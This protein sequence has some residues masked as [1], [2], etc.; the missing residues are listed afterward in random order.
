MTRSAI[1]CVRPLIAMKRLK[2]V[3]NMK[4]TMMPAVRRRVRSMD[5]QNAVEREA[6]HQ[7]RDNQRAENAQP[8]RFV[9]R[10]QSGIDAAQ[11]QQHQQQA[12]ARSWRS[13]RD[14]RASCCVRR[15]APERRI[16]RRAHG[17]QHDQDE[18]EQDARQDARDEQ[19]ADRDLGDHAVDDEGEARRHHHADGRRAGDRRRG[20]L[21]VV[22]VGLHLRQRDRAHAVDAGQGVS[23][24]RRKARA[25]DRAGRREPARQ[26]ADPPVGRAVELLGKARGD[27]DQPHPGEQRHD[28]PGLI[29]D[30]VDGRRAEAGQ[31]RRGA[32][33]QADAD[34]RGD[35]HRGGD[36]DAEED[37]D[38]AEADA[39]DAAQIA[40][41]A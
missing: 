1:C 28:A 39:Q 4:I 3:A 35:R 21:H 37:Q 11:D 12:P 24:D 33:Q 40:R 29:A 23:D 9:G 17:D 7:H 8:A 14:A 30:H 41:T 32:D 6:P 5:C 10:D 38:E 34:Q 26:V 16:E 13:T 31:A 22:A 20:K 27:D 36:M 19:L 2:A 25:G 15:A 18:G